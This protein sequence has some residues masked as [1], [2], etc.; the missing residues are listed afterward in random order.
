M[1]SLGNPNKPQKGVKVEGEV[2]AKEED[3]VKES[4]L[5]GDLFKPDFEN[6]ISACFKYLGKPYTQGNPEMKGIEAPIRKWLLTQDASVQL[7][8]LNAYVEVKPKYTF[9]TIEKLLEGLGGY[10]YCQD[11]K[12][13]SPSTNGQQQKSQE[14][15]DSEK[16]E[17]RLIREKYKEDIAANEKSIEEQESDGD[18]EKLKSDIGK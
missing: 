10:N 5:I 1:G 17:E 4:P 18:F 6:F 16:E 14:Q 12:T 7:K 2:K 13:Y 9:K 3:E 8:N 15:L 11:L